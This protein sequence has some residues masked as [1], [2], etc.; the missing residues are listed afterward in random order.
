MIKKIFLF[1]FVSLLAGCASMGPLSFLP[2]NKASDGYTIKHKLNKKYPG[3]PHITIEYRD[4]EK[5]YNERV[6]MLDNM[7]A[8]DNTRANGLESVPKGGMVLIRIEKSII[9][10]ANTDNFIYVLY[11]DGNEFDR[12]EGQHNLPYYDVGDYGTTWHNT[13]VLSIQKPIIDSVTL[14][15]I[16]KMGGRDEFTISIQKNSN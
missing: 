12:K 15:V 16:D 2:Q 7:L 10:A 9:E 11:R 14:Y 6:E 1:I 5:T 3:Y 13:D 4:Y 8:D